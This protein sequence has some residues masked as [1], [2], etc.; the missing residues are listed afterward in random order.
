MIYEILEHFVRALK[1][2]T[3]GAGERPTHARKV[4][5]HYRGG[6]SGLGRAAAVALG[7]MGADLFLIGRNQRAAESVIASAKKSRAGHVEFVLDLQP[8]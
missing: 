2:G 7:S 6:T 1:Y 8:R 4:M 5:R 3:I